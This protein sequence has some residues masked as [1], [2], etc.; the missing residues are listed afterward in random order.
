MGKV[1]PFPCKMV[2]VKVPKGGNVMRRIVLDM[3]CVLFADA[4]SQAL[5]NNDPDFEPR[6]TE[7][8][9]DAVRLCRSSCAYAIIMEV[10]PYSPW[11]LEER[12]RLSKEIKAA[13]SD[14][15]VV[16][17][18]DEKADAAL[19]AE[20]RQAKKDGLVDNFI[21][22]SVSPTYLSAVIDAL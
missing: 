22:A 17:L 8:P 7:E 10:T 14:C 11:R 18:V 21:Y 2:T 16:L 15:R 19:A 3:Q 13:V 4:I 5:M 1:F 20:V 12:L 6:R 9:S